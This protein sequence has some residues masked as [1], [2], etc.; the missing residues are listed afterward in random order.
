MKTIS[1]IGKA[2]LSRIFKPESTMKGNFTTFERTVTFPNEELS[3]TKCIFQYEGKYGKNKE[4]TFITKVQVWGITIGLRN[5]EII[6]DGEILF[7]S[8]WPIQTWEEKAHPSHIII[9]NS[10]EYLD[11]SDRC[12]SIHEDVF[13]YRISEKQIADITKRRD[14]SIFENPIPEFEETEEL[15][16][17]EKRDRHY[18]IHNPDHRDMHKEDDW[19]YE[20]TKS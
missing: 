18:E 8:L 10:K 9:I 1:Q 6:Q 13:I 16:D 2:A 12:G 15:S 3:L 4:T 19:Q 17:E 14:E 20:P 5:L 11:Y 7:E